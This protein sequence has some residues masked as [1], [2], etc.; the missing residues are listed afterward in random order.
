[1]CKLVEMVVVVVGCLFAGE[2][3][4][5]RMFAGE[6]EEECRPAGEVA[7]GRMRSELQ[8]VVLLLGEVEEDLLWKLWEAEEVGEQRRFQFEQEATEL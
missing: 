7:A 2:V 6:V 8:P 1:M 4:E 3:E 5:E